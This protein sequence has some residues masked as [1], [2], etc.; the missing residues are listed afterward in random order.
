MDRAQ[1]LI[2]YDHENGRETLRVGL[3]VVTVTVD[4]AGV[5]KIDFGEL[6]KLGTEIFRMGVNAKTRE[7]AKLFQQMT[8]EMVR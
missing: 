7:V 4:D 1:D 2:V 5:C 8:E 6:R 3:R